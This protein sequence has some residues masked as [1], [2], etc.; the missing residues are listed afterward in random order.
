MMGYNSSSAPGPLEYYTLKRAADDM[1]LLAKHLNAPRIILLGHDWGGAIV[2]R[3][4][5]WHPSLICGIISICTPFTRPQ[6]DYQPIEKLVKTALPNFAYQIQLASGEVEEK[7]KSKEDIKQFLNAMYGGKGPNH[8]VGFVAEKGVLFDNLPKLEPN[9]LLSEEELEYY[10][11]CYS[12]N[13]L[14]GPLNWYRTRELN[15]KDEKVL[16]EVKDL[17]IK[18][19]VLF[20]VAKH[21]A[22]LPPSMA[23]GMEKSFGDLTI[24]EVDASH[25][26]LWQQPEECNAFIKEFFVEK[27]FSGEEEKS[28]L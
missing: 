28:M 16:A 3:I 19:P 17:R 22:A 14:R 1:Y 6:K 23:R 24:K 9:R 15:F 18:C 25:W 4:A 13:G 2:Y 11:E 21:D 8:E 10:A 5:L 20:V 7:I 26:A 12:R 27:L